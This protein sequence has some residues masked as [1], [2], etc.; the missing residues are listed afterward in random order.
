MEFFVELLFLSL[1]DGSIA[2]ELFSLS[3]EIVPLLFP[4]FVEFQ[5]VRHQWG[6]LMRKGLIGMGM[7]VGLI[8]PVALMMMGVLI[9]V[10][11]VRSGMD[12]IGG[13][14][15]LGGLFIAD[16]DVVEVGEIGSVEVFLQG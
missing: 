11:S 3:A 13:D 12:R 8:L 16:F 7:G 15:G 6:T 5:G 1:E 4:F 2:T 14:F 9:M 10:S